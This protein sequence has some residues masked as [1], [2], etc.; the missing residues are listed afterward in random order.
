LL[1]QIEQPVNICI[2]VLVKKYIQ[3]KLF[4]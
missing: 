2:Y 4:E 3:N 1:R